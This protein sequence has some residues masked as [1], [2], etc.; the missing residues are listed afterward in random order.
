M[1]ILLL[2]LII[3]AA[4]MFGW[5]LLSGLAGLLPLAFIVLG[6]K[7]L[8]PRRSPEASALPPR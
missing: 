7:L 8:R 1:E 3:P 5:L 6:G 2:L 4:I